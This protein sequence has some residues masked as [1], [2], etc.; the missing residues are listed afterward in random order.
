[1]HSRRPSAPDV[2]AVDRPFDAPRAS[3][4]DGP[5]PAIASRLLGQLLD[6][7]ADLVCAAGADG[8]L[9]YAN[10]AWERALGHAAAGAAAPRL[11]DLVAP[12]DRER[13][14][15][16]ARSAGGSEVAL[17]LLARDGRRVAC[18]GRVAADPA[19]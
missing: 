17:T 1:M 14:V 6:E 11:V 16:A 12:E 3:A 9:G 19:E 18:R 8:R 4:G 2:A 5:S 15:A 10:R 13:C 7:T